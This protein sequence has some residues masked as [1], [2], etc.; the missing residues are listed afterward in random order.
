MTSPTFEVLKFAAIP[1]VAT[2]VGGA[3]ASYRTPSPR[4][5]S[6]IQHFAAGVVLAAVA[7]EVVPELMHHHSPVA[8][9]VGF[10]LGVAAM[11]G[12]K[13]LTEGPEGAS[14]ESARPPKRLLTIVGVDISIDGLLIGVGFAAGA[15]QGALLTI[16][17]TLEVLFL[18][19]ATAASLTKSGMAPSRAI[20]SVAGL[21]GLLLAGATVGAL[22]QSLLVGVVLVGV[23]GFASAALLYLVVEELLTEAHEV[24][25]TP[26]STAV[27]FLG[28]LVLFL[29]E[30]MA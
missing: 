29:V 20:T 21:A 23:L 24:P 28:F 18:G 14:E 2:V 7:G 12:V 15:K 27:F 16:A 19:V 26:V 3:A 17:L 25:E 11:L 9:A 13:A 22:L 10:M 30:M 1:V 8:T 5:R 4:V 6:T